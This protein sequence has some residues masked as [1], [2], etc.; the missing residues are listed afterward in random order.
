[1]CSGVIGPV[2]LRAG[3]YSTA[4]VD[5]V[6]EGTCRTRPGSENVADGMEGGD[7]PMSGTGSVTASGAPAALVQH[8]GAWLAHGRFELGG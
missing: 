6:L 5:K 7:P 1:V 4:W 3:C 2:C 8:P